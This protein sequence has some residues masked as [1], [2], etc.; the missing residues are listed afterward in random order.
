ME[1][2]IPPLAEPQTSNSEVT[3]Q[4]TTPPEQPTKPYGRNW[5][6]WILF[7]VV[8]AI[9]ILGIGSL[10]LSQSKSNNAN[11]LSKKAKGKTDVNNF[12]TCA[13]AGNPIM[14]SYPRQCSANDKNFTEIIKPSP[15]P[16]LI[17]GWKTYTNEKHGYSIKYPSNYSLPAGQGDRF[18]I[19]SPQDPTFGFQDGDS[20]IEI[21][22]EASPSEDT[23][24]KILS[25]QKKELEKILS[26]LE[27][28]D[29]PAKVKEIKIVTINGVR[30]VHRYTSQAPLNFDLYTFIHNQKR[31][32]IAKYPLITSRQSEFD[33]ILQTFKFT[34]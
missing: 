13:K 33:Q 16:D 9:V 10:T 20:K 24:E 15:T 19:M 26:E 17:A 29:G 21:F 31:I 32:Y 23:L 6:K 18:A 30:A 3:P 1:N 34:K 8:L 5:K 7:G 4:V 11:I 28:Q 25:E 2:Q 27:P 12:E 22:A 14:E